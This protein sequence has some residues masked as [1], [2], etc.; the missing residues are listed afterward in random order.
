MDPGARFNGLLIGQGVEHGRA[1]ILARG[2]NGLL[3]GQG[4]APGVSRGC[5]PPARQVP[6]PLSSA[7]ALGA[8]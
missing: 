7:K 3:I 6:M 8:A 1:Y 4:V 2:F 5:K